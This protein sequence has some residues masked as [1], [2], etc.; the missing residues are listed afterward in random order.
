[1]TERLTKQTV[2]WIFTKTI[3]QS[4]LNSSREN[5]IFPIQTDRRTNKAEG[6][7]LWDL[8]GKCFVKEDIMV[9]LIQ[10]DIKIYILILTTKGIV[11]KKTENKSELDLY[12]HHNNINI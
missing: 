10:T 6:G 8:I 12:L 3:T 5:Y 9:C 7:M 4:I 1:M 2:Y 11:F